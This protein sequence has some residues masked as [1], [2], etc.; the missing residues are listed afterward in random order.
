MLSG[1]MDGR[2][3]EVRSREDILAVPLNCLLP[4][5]CGGVYR[6]TVSML[7]PDGQHLAGNEDMSDAGTIPSY[8][9]QNVDAI[10]ARDALVKFP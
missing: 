10:H 3:G 5:G 4:R 2:G 1:S 8:R 9:K 7:Q 6:A